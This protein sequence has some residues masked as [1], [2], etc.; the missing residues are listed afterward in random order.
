MQMKTI[1]YVSKAVGQGNASLLPSTLVHILYQARKANT[2]YGVSGAL[3]YHDG[4]FFQALEGP[5]D[6]VDTLF[7]NIL[8]DKRHKEVNVV[9][10]R[11]TNFRV[12]SNFS[13]RMMHKE[14]QEPLIEYINAYFLNNSTRSINA[15]KTLSMFMDLNSIYNKRETLLKSNIYRNKNLSLTRWPRFT[16]SP[17]LALVELCVSLKQ[18]PKSYEFHVN[19]NPFD[20][21][22]MLNEHLE[23]LHRNGLLI[24][25]DKPSNLS[26]NSIKESLSSSHFYQKMRHFLSIEE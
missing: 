14:D 19:Q 3:A 4:S 18:F 20:T 12:F 13:M 11:E 23:Q 1:F 10:E 15:L 8:K 24:V 26:Y 9:Y 5:I 17:S 7:K 2:K 22:S 21:V 25:E 16:R 6:T